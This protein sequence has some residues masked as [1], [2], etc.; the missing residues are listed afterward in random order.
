MWWEGNGK[1]IYSC[2]ALTHIDSVAVCAAFFFFFFFSLF[3]VPFSLCLC[4]TLCCFFCYAHSHI[5]CSP[6]KFIAWLQLPLFLSFY[7]VAQWSKHFLEAKMIYGV[8][9]ISS[10][11]NSSS[12][13]ERKTKSPLH[14]LSVSLSLSLLL[15]QTNFPIFLRFDVIF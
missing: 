6:R 8:E 2:A 14:S 7:V 9:V 13:I 11:W 10:F 15:L 1:F 4:I 3:Y 5:G 12:S